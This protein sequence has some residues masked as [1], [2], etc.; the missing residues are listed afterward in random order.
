MGKWWA[1]AAGDFHSIV[2]TESGDIYSWGEN[3][4]GQLGD[5]TTKAINKPHLIKGIAGKV[6]SIAAGDY[7]SVALTENGDIYNW[8]ENRFGQLGDGTFKNQHLP[9]LITD[10]PGK[11]I[12]IATGIYHTLALLGNGKVYGWGSNG[13]GQLG[14]GTV[15]RAMHPQLIKKIP[16]KVINIAA[17]TF[18]TLALLENGKVYGCGNNE[19]EELGRNKN[20]FDLFLT[21]KRISIMEKR[22]ML[23]PFGKGGWAVGYTELEEKFRQL[24]G[25]EFYL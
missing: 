7:Y 3:T 4:F 23:A 21:P 15:N 2:L 19:R 5:G 6:V 12:S 9:Q 13:F 10:L 18:Q 14:D 20:Q 8:G 17:G 22:I 11:A 1:V 25:H 24:L 16:G